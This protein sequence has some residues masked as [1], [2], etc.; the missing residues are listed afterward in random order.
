MGEVTVEHRVAM[1]I[2]DQLKS[3]GI[4]YWLS[5]DSSEVLNHV[6]GPSSAGTSGLGIL[7]TIVVRDPDTERFSQIC[8]SHLKLI[9]EREVPENRCFRNHWFWKW[10]F[11]S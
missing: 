3:E 9:H 4:R 11:R 1:K 10:L 6:P 5:S 7:T 2:V 8:D